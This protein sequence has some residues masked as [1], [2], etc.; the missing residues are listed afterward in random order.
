MT[1]DYG[2]KILDTRDIIERH[3]ELNSE[4]AALWSDAVDA[5]AEGDSVPLAHLYEWVTDD[6][7]LD[8]EFVPSVTGEPDLKKIESWIGSDDAEELQDLTAVIET[9]DGYCPDF[10]YGETLI[11]DTHF[12]DYAYELAHDVC[13]NLNTTDWP[14]CHID[15]AAAA[16]AL[17]MDYSCV[18]IAGYEYWFRN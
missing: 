3:D 13:Q 18:D 12:E 15:W 1:I 11:R 2:D 6:S 16:E 10:R 9:L 7:E 4:F 8:E 5:A 14:Y 17:K